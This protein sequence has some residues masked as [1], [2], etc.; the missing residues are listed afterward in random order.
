ML[1]YHC[2]FRFHCMVVQIKEGIPMGVLEV[3]LDNISGKLATSLAGLITKKSKKGACLELWMLSLDAAPRAVSK[4]GLGSV[5][6][7]LDAKF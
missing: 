7:P 3:N 1:F 6:G 5:I 4:T 2:S